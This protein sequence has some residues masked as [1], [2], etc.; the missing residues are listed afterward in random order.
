MAKFTLIYVSDE[1]K[2]IRRDPSRSVTKKGVFSKNAKTRF[3]GRR[4]D[5]SVTD[6]LRIV[7]GASVTGIFIRKTRFCYGCDGSFSL[8]K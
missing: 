4:C 1:E 3:F 6:R 2:S 8:K 7:W 5:G